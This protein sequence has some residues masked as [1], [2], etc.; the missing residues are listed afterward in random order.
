MDVVGVCLLSLDWS[1]QGDGIIYGLSGKTKKCDLL[2]GKKTKK[3]DSLYLFIKMYSNL[4]VYFQRGEIS[5]G[6][7]YEP[8]FADISY[9]FQVALKR[10]NL[11][12]RDKSSGAA[13]Q[14]PK[15]E[16]SLP[17]WDDIRYYIHG[18]TVLYFNE[19][20]WKIL[21]T[22][23][24]YEKVD[25]LQIVSEYM[26]I[27][28]TDGHVDVSAK[29]FGMYISSLESMMKNCSLKVPSGVP[30]PFIYAPLFSLNVII[31]WQCE[32]GSPLNH[33]LHAL[34]IEGEPRKKVY[35]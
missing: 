18:K 15:K 33:Y 14:P 7:G 8:S 10:V 19:T 17:W 5:F 27:Q 3:C 23:N 24:P 13:N 25:R 26:E 31:D 6:V 1:L 30:R 29:E 32:S 9:A 21:A 22:T 16:R 28:Q 4:P 12:S 35:I 34:P 11:S 20:K 2:F